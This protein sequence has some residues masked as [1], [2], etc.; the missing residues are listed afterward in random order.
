M[1]FKAW[2]SARKARPVDSS[3]LVVATG[4]RR[5]FRSLIETPARLN[6]AGQMRE[7]RLLDISLQGALVE[8]PP[9][10]QSLVGTRGRLRLSLLPTEVISM[11]VAVARTQGHCL[12]LRCVNIDLDS[13]THLRQLVARNSEDPQ[14]V[15][16]DLA[17]LI[18]HA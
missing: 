9:G 16:L 11:D 13:I 18:G 6:L 8:A 7:V 5:F 15:G 3:A 10:L 17:R 4:H 14:W 1:L 2:P 12:G